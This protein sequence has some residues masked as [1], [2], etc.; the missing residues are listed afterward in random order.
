[1]VQFQTNLSIIL[2]L[3]IFKKIANIENSIY[4]KMCKECF[5]SVKWIWALN[6]EN[7]KQNFFI[8]KK[9]WCPLERLAGG[10]IIL[11][12]KI[13][14]SSTPGPSRANATGSL[15]TPG[16]P[17][18]E[19]SSGELLA[20]LSS[21]ATRVLGELLLCAPWQLAARCTWE[22]PQRSGTVLLG[23]FPDGW[24]VAPGDADMRSGGFW[25][26]TFPIL[27][28]RGIYVLHRL[29]C[30]TG[31]EWKGSC[32]SI[33]LLSD[34]GTVLLLLMGIHWLIGGVPFYCPPSCMALYW[35]LSPLLV[36]VIVFLICSSLSLIPLSFTTMSFPVYYQSIRTFLSF[37]LFN[38]VVYLVVA[39]LILVFG[40]FVLFLLLL[41]FWSVY[42]RSKQC[43]KD[44]ILESPRF[45]VIEA[46]QMQCDD[47]I[48]HMGMVGPC[49]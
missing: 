43:L 14:L 19:Q 2:P 13:T 3:C 31:I 38:C 1:M 4:I 42:T 30:V 36:M 10:R 16:A 22:S 37:W 39:P 25:F 33:Y 20:P 8:Y 24:L 21:C 6:V 47:H 17:R 49:L 45:F 23:H 26:S 5:V 34:D 29:L 28:F 35:H 40:R 11:L 48:Y 9:V 32:H 12:S 15:K 44:L 41:L 7:Y 18:V 27:F 46:C